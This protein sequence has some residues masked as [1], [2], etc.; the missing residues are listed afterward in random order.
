VRYIKIPRSGRGLIT[1]GTDGVF[2]NCGL[3]LEQDRLSK[4]YDKVNTEVQ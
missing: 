2:D 1:V 3:E 4:C